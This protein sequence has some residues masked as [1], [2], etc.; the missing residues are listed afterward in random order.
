MNF[1]KV[2]KIF[3]HVY[4]FQ[5]FTPLSY[6]YFPYEKKA[7]KKYKK[8]NKYET[9]SLVN[10]IKSKRIEKKKTHGMKLKQ[11]RG[12]HNLILYERIIYLKERCVSTRINVILLCIYYN[13]N[14]RVYNSV[15][16][17]CFFFFFGNIFA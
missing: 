10:I 9:G 11:L 5:L 6:P 7:S 8:I 1:N 2:I 17:Q 12:V 15:L 14:R 3:K 13:Y 4:L 16:F